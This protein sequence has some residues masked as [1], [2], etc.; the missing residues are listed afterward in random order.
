MHSI[1]FVDEFTFIEGRAR[2]LATAYVV[3]LHV[4]SREMQYHSRYYFAKM[5]FVIFLVQHNACSPLPK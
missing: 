4:Y 5:P 3:S 1:H 2:A